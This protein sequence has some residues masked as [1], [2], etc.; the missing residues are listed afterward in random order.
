[1]NKLRR[2]VIFLARII[3]HMH[4]ILFLRRHRRATEITISRAVVMWQKHVKRNKPSFVLC[5][6]QIIA[7]G[8]IAFRWGWWGLS[9][10][11][12]VTIFQ[13]CSSTLRIVWIC[14]Y[15][16]HHESKLGMTAKWLVCTLK[17]SDCRRCTRLAVHVFH[18]VSDI[19]I[20]PSILKPRPKARAKMAGMVNKVYCAI[21]WRH[22]TTAT[23]ILPMFFSFFFF[24][25][26]GISEKFK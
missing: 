3:P 15:C 21:S 23:R 8:G 25:L 16:F 1:M 11:L 9:L 17:G 18:T 24:N 7:S 22:F 6:F 13:K 14:R 2:M 10:L 20:I 26:S 19:A 5:S 4:I 12:F